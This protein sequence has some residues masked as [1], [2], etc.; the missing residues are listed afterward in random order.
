MDGVT[1]IWSVRGGPCLAVRWATCPP[2][3]DEPT[4]D[5]VACS[6][7]SSPLP[8]PSTL[9]LAI[10]SPRSERSLFP[11]HH[12]PL[13]SHRP[14]HHTKNDP[15]IPTDYMEYMLKY[16]S[17][18][19]KPDYDVE[20]GDGFVMVGGKK[21]AITNEMDPANIRWG[22]SGAEYIVESTGQFLTDDTARKHMNGGAKK[23]VL[24]APSKDDTPMFV[25]GV[26]EGTYDG[27]DIVSNASCTT[28]CLAPLAKVRRG[29]GNTGRE[30]Q[31]VCVCE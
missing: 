18:H 9:S 8:R 4:V 19:G 24:S 11:P 30:R 16:D 12:P 28:N 27:Q 5:E 13:P 7:P 6:H 1:Q 31:C 22:D 2:P 29:G 26:N 20:A 15:F 25:M 23:V 3:L 14:P 17:T 10:L 21:I